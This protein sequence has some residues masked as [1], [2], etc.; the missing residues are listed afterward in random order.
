M[1]FLFCWAFLFKPSILNLHSSYSCLQRKSIVFLKKVWTHLKTLSNLNLDLLVDDQ[2]F[3]WV[4]KLYQKNYRQFEAWELTSLNPSNFKQSSTFVRF[5]KS[6]WFEWECPFLSF[7]NPLVNF[8][9]L[10]FKIK[11][12]SLFLIR[13]LY[14]GLKHLLMLVLGLFSLKVFVMTSAWQLGDTL[15]KRPTFSEAL[16]VLLDRLLLAEFVAFEN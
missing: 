14:L 15:M 16:L 7:S 13:K 5:L 2:L 4:P 3:K 6:L 9:N 11:F 12:V 1:K 8:S 10:I